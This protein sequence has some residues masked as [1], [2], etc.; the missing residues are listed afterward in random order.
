MDK[1]KTN[2]LYYGDNLKILREHIPDNSIDLIYLDPPFNSK[3]DYNILFKEN[4]GVESEAQI[5]AFTDTWHWTQSAQNTYHDIVTTGPLKV[6]QLIGALHDAIGQNDVMAYLVMMTARLIELHRVLKP[7]GSLYLHCDPTMSHY[8]KLILDQIFGASNFQNEIIWFYKT[9]GAS[10][11]RFARKHDTIF[12]YTKSGRYRFNPQKEK[13]YMMHEYGF[14]K[15]N[16]QKDELGQYSWV[17]TKDVWEIP[18]VGSA[19]KERLGYPTQKPFDLLERITKASSKEGDVVLD[20][21]CGCGTTIV[22]AQKLNRRWIGIDITHLAITLMKNRI[23]DSFGNIP[24]E[25]IGEPEDLAGARA[26]A[27]QDRYQFQYWALGLIKARPLGEKKKGADK[28]IDGVIQFIDDASGKAK[29]AVV[30]VKSGHVSVNAVRELKA[31]AVHDALGI[32]ITLEPPTQP[33]LTEAV[34]TGI[35]HSPGWDKD[36]PKIQILTIEELL[37]GKTVDMPPLTQTG[38]TFAKAP[39]VSTEEGEQL[40]M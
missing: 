6:G 14:K 33:M 8:I 19:T 28:G 34:S 36:Y 24:I 29:R 21:F 27:H 5:K 30:Q 9:G 32:F 15:S 23:Q 16:F 1:L 37:Q 40:S 18:A 38:I 12:F 35:Y 4:G 25:V 31:V 11:K 13:S 2:V 20:P 39:K 10:A 17:Y 26:L 22:A 7:T 3:K